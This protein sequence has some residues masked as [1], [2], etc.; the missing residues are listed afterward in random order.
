MSEDPSKIHEFL[1]ACNP[2]SPPPAYTAG[3][4]TRSEER[5][6]HLDFLLP[7]SAEDVLTIKKIDDMKADISPA[8]D[9]SEH[10][11]SVTIRALREKFLRLQDKVAKMGKDIRDLEN[12]LQGNN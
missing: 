4:K 12:R 8:V 10:E 3:K 11:E 1:D 2:G 5:N 6:K 7:Q 9:A